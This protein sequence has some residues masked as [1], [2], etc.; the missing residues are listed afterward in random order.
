MRARLLERRG[1]N[2]PVLMHGREPRFWSSR[3][4]LESRIRHIRRPLGRPISC[5]STPHSAELGN[6][7][8]PLLGAVQ[9]QQRSV[10]R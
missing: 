5:V 8:S 7:G 4:Q 6:K 3:R 10:T 9:H 2:L 1:R